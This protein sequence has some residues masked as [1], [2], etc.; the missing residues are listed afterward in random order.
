[1]MIVEL[2]VGDRVHYEPTYKAP[3]NGI[4]K[5]IPEEGLSVFVVYNCDGDWNNYQNY[6]GALT[7]VRYLKPGWVL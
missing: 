6:T 1:M 3:E 7:D 5:S 2:N 4:V